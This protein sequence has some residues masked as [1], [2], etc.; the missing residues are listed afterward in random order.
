M[1]GLAILM[2]YFWK[3]N[4]L[5]SVWFINNIYM[6]NNTFCSITLYLLLYQYNNLFLLW[7][8]VNYLKYTNTISAQFF[9]YLLL[10]MKPGMIYIIISD[11][12]DPLTS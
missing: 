2:K 6:M 4:E 5:C 11:I 8:R 7:Y 9:H 1:Y 12:T 3:E 10:C